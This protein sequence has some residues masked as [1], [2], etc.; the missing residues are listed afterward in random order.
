MAGMEGADTLD[1]LVALIQNHAQARNDIILQTACRL[2]AQVANEPE[3]RQK[4]VLLGVVPCLLPHVLD[5]NVETVK[6]A[7]LAL[8][9]LSY[10]ESARES[11]ADDLFLSRAIAMLK[12]TDVALKQLASLVLSNICFSAVSAPAVVAAGGVEALTAGAK[13]PEPVSQR[14][15]LKALMNLTGCPSAEDRAVRAGTLSL[16]FSFV[17]KPRPAGPAGQ[18]NLLVAL[19]ALTNAVSA[20]DPLRANLFSQ[21]ALMPLLALLRSPTDSVRE[22]SAAIIAGLM[23]GGEDCARRKALKEAGGL[24]M[25]IALLDDTSPNVR[26]KAVRAIAAIS[27]DPALRDELIT[28]H[29]ILHPVLEMLAV[30]DDKTVLHAVVLIQCVCRSSGN[31]RLLRELGGVAGLLGTVT[32]CGLEVKNGA[33]RALGTLLT[34]DPAVGRVLVE[35]GAVGVLVGLLEEGNDSVTVRVLV[36]LWDMIKDGK[37]ECDL[38]ESGISGLV[39]P[40]T[41]HDD[42]I[43]RGI[44]DKIIQTLDSG[45]HDITVRLE[46]SSPATSAQGTVPPSSKRPARPPAPPG[47]INGEYSS[48]HTGNPNAGAIIERNDQV[49][50][51]RWVYR[52]ITSGAAKV[53]KWIF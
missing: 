5:P 8:A 30:D 22:L 23:E 7:L 45:M 29:G 40:L 19:S 11:M 10:D 32:R 52:G 38:R 2:V 51:I 17:A 26:S 14:E 16:L 24:S 9:G 41:S 43:I 6:L 18:T 50:I 28:H 44:A 20:S 25:L 49:G 33:L 47:V 12:S 46:Q 1:N 37:V 36:I 13:D 27:N 34:Y 31:A 48:N 15:C 42:N 53:F 4:L 35:V 21:G 39:A 3:V